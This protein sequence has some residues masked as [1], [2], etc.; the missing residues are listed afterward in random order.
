MTFGYQ[1]SEIAFNIA[2]NVF[3]R[4]RI[5]ATCCLLSKLQEMASYVCL[6][7]YYFIEENI[8]FRYVVCG[9]K[10]MDHW[11]N[12]FT[13]CSDWSLSFLVHLLCRLADRPGYT[14]DPCSTRSTAF[15]NAV[16]S[17]FR[18]STWKP[19]SVSRYFYTGYSLLM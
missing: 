17:L 4:L 15:V 11:K 19:L 18:I 16:A 5:L 9:S 10:L 13:L 8:F 12:I 1:I 7:F 6:F 14:V 3:S 2:P